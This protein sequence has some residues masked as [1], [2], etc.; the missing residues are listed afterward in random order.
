MFPPLLDQDLGFPEGIKDL[1][2]E[3]LVAAGRRARIRDAAV[4]KVLG[5]GRGDLL[6]AHALEFALIGAAA[7]TVAVAVGGLTAWAFV[8]QIMAM[9]WSFSPWRALLTVLGGT[10]I[11]AAVGFAGTWR[12][13]ARKAA[14]LLRGG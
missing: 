12:A 2:V 5:A 14:P 7:G 8:S 3:Q 11:T 9:E 4:L 13:M 10:A 1:P 6:R